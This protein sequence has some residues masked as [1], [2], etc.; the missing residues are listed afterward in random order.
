MLVSVNKAA[1]KFYTTTKFPFNSSIDPKKAPQH[2]ITGDWDFLAESIDTSNMDKVVVYEDFSALIKWVNFLG[3]N[4][5]AFYH[6]D[7]NFVKVVAN[8]GMKCYTGDMNMIPKNLHGVGNPAFSISE[9]VLLNH[10]TSK[11]LCMVMESKY[12]LA[13]NFKA[14]GW[15]NVQTIKER[16][17][18]MGLKE[19]YHIPNGFFKQMQSDGKEKAAQVQSVLV[20]TEPGYTGQV[21]VTNLHSKE[22]FYLDRG[23]PYVKTSTIL[24]EVEL[25][26][27]GNDF[28]FRELQKSDEVAESWAIGVN[29]YNP[30]AKS[31]GVD[32]NH[33][34]GMQLFAPGDTMKK[35][36]CYCYFNDEST[37][38]KMH[39]HFS[40]KKVA[41]AYQNITTQKSFSGIVTRM[42]KV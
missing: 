36:T 24:P 23:V 20:I 6:S 17:E 41:D 5:V 29:V 25:Y 39:T 11:S 12:V 33:L 31:S 19:V 18:K 42:L 2:Y 35:N 32:G 26:G 38:R 14:N 10:P 13:P 9:K 7:P 8:Q 15:K 3:P 37:A 4:N 16:L 40:S 27:Q 34:E 30:N 1:K 28:K 21:K 22:S